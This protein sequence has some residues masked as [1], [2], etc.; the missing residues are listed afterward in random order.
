MSQKRC[1]VISPIGDEGSPVRKH[2]DDV[3]NIIVRP[4][5][6]ACGVEA[7][8]ADKLY[9]PGRITDQMFREILNADFCIALLTGQNPNVFYEMAVAQ[10]AGKPVIPLIAE[11]EK[12][13]LP[14]DVLDIRCIYYDFE[15]Q[16]V[17]EKKYEKQL[18]EYVHRLE[19]NKWQSES[20]LKRYGI[21]NLKWLLSESYSYEELAS[22]IDRTITNLTENHGELLLEYKADGDAERLFDGL[23]SSILYAS[24]AATTGTVNAIFYGNLMELDAGKS[25]LRVRY[26]AGPYNENVITR[27][28][29]VGR[30]GE[31]IA[32]IAFN[33]QKIQVVNSMGHELKVKGEARLNAMISVPIPGI[34][35]NDR[36]RQI[37]LLNIDS[38]VT[39]V[40][41]PTETL[42][43][44][45]CGRR[46][47]RLA[48]L[49]SRTNVL[50][51]WIVEGTERAEIPDLP[52][53][54]L[55]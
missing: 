9:E 40:F 41:P 36:S 20:L 22:E 48:T 26:F 4:A 46:L 18:I 37:A 13:Q 31:G 10:S 2:A 35:R 21:D 3:L 12:N 30:R 45:P 39:D 7:L 50:Y 51:K 55:F 6:T 8:R 53:G 14:F 42:R 44:D 49:V 27:S 54:A 16:N 24:R 23:Y 15:P 1:F 38:G 19:H 28:F 11:E 5:M 34:N 33:S 29:P 17:H 47:E 25:Q 32:T 52:P 43:T